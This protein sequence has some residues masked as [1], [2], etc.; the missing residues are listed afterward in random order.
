MR[1]I[2]VSGLCLL[3]LAG[4]ARTREVQVGPSANNVLSA[5]HVR[6]PKRVLME[7]VSGKG[8]VWRQIIRKIQSGDPRW[9]AVAAAFKPASDAGY[10][11]DLN[12]A[13]AEALPK[14][15]Q[16]VL[17]SPSFR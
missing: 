10:S 8:Q 11:E 1:A 13:V 3:W 17:G 16:G 14:N 9:L 4:A 15:P 6:G 7:Y 5:I 12:F 2:A